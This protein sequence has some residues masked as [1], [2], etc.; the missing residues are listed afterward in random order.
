MCLFASQGDWKE[1]E[2]TQ[3]SLRKTAKQSAAQNSFVIYVPK[4]LTFF[5]PKLW[6]LCFQGIV[7]CFGHIYCVQYTI[8]SF[9]PELFNIKNIC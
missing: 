7:I 9:E 3:L 5:C 1:L 8:F 2:Q 4:A 6:P